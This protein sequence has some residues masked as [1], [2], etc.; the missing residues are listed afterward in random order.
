MEVA[1]LAP[2][3]S[4]RD[5]SAARDR[6]RS[7][8]GGAGRGAGHRRRARPAARRADGSRVESRS[9]AVCSSVPQPTPPD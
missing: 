4:T 8:P 3:P 9:V 2:I 7:Q 1:D 6:D 5:E